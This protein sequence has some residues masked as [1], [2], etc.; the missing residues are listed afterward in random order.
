M[1]GRLHERY[2][3][4][5]H[6]SIRTY[7][8]WSSTQCVSSGRS[9]A[10]AVQVQGKPWKAIRNIP[11]DREGDF[12][13]DLRS[14]AQKVADRLLIEV[15]VKDNVKIVT[16]RSTYKLENQTLYP[17]DVVLVDSQGKPSHPLQKL[18]ECYHH[19]QD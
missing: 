7:T 3:A 12:I 13:Y 5:D 14:R 11:V 19:F 6:A 18:G 15:T 2:D 10:V 17:I 1:T 4:V 16:L 8:H 9:N